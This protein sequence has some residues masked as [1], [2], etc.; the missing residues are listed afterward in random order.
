MPSST[1]R[2][3]TIR[4]RVL[5]A[6][7]TVLVLIVGAAGIRGVL[8]E[9]RDA[10]QA[11]HEQESLPLAQLDTIAQALYRIQLAVAHAALDPNKAEVA[12]AGPVVEANLQLVD[13]TWAGYMGSTLAA[14]PAVQ[15]Q[16]VAFAAS[17]ERFIRDGV[18]PALAAL[19]AGDL[20][21]A[22]RLVNDRMRSLRQPLDQE[23]SALLAIH[24]DQTRVAYAAA[25]VRHESLKTRAIG[26]LLLVLGATWVLGMRCLR[27]LGRH[28]AAGAE[29][30]LADAPANAPSHAA[31]A[32]Q[33]AAEAA[34]TGN[35]A[36]GWRG[37][38]RRGPNRARNVSRPSF[39]TNQA[40]RDEPAFDSTDETGQPPRKTG[41]TGKA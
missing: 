26:A 20:R 33:P 10:L 11:G 32:D 7:I 34:V 17:R 35:L 29:T 18:Q 19:K 39:R 30:A 24:G 31:E 21:S 3:S 36:E 13:A 15:Q 8:S 12:A 28:L 16:M 9:S 2:R 25:V 22:R 40:A 27:G 5:Q 38:E 6:L 23:L 1:A 4:L 41:T 37:P 14:A